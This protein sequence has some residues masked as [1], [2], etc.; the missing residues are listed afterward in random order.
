VFQRAPIWANR[1]AAN[2]Q[3]RT[4][5]L[6]LIARENNRV[7][8]VSEFALRDW[9]TPIAQV[10]GVHT[11]VVL[12]DPISHPYVDRREGFVRD[13]AVLGREDHATRKQLPRG[14]LEPLAIELRWN[15]VERLHKVNEHAHRESCRSRVPTG[16]GGRGHPQPARNPESASCLR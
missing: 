16:Y 4:P 5:T 1:G 8:R 15:A 6:I 14:H 10:S 3:K 7:L 13:D 11:N 2:L 9:I 12:I